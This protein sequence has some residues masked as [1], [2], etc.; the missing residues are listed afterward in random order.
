MLLLLA[1]IAS[2]SSASPVQPQPV[3]AL[4]DVVL[5]DQLGQSLSLRGI[6]YRVCSH[7]L[8]ANSAVSISNMLSVAKGCTILPLLILEAI[9]LR[10]ALESEGLAVGILEGLSGGWLIRFFQMHQVVRRHAHNKSSDV[11]KTTQP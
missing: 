8:V 1:I 3:F 5:L 11:V 4:L 10:P 6:V 9:H 7:N 2:L